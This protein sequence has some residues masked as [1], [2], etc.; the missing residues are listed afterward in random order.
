MSRTLV[1]SFDGYEEPLAVE[2]FRRATACHAERE[3]FAGLRTFVEALPD[4]PEEPWRLERLARVERLAL[5]PQVVA[6]ARWRAW[7][8]R[9]TLALLDR[10]E[11]RMVSPGGFAM[12]ARRETLHVEL[13]CQVDWIE[14]LYWLADPAHRV[15]VRVD[16]VEDEARRFDLQR[17]HELEALVELLVDDRPDTPTR[18]ALF[19][20]PEL[21]TS[22]GQVIMID[23]ESEL[24]W[25]AAAEVAATIPLVERALATT[26]PP[27]AEYERFRDAVSGVAFEDAPYDVFLAEVRAGADRL[28]THRR[29]LVAAGHAELLVR[30]SY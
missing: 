17:I 7:P 6:H 18:R 22:E 20:R 19:G 23:P 13:E 9:E 8:R 11:G 4:P 30:G 2:L 5:P 21:P 3:S 25:L 14:G 15:L 10:G 24:G 12:L 16:E 28:L 1:Y 26:P 27:A 29:A